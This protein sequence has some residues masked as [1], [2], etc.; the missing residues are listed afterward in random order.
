LALFALSLI[1]IGCRSDRGI[2]KATG[3]LIALA[4]LGATAHTT[5]ADHPGAVIAF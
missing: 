2:E 3:T 1:F 4:A 5:R